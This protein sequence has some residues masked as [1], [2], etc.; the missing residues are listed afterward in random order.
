MILSVQTLRGNFFAKSDSWLES[1]AVAHDAIIP[2]DSLATVSL[3]FEWRRGIVSILSDVL[4]QVHDAADDAL[5]D[6]I[7][8]LI[9]AFYTDQYD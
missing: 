4:E 5:Y 9:S 2:G 6:Q 8:S 3:N 1:L 7:E